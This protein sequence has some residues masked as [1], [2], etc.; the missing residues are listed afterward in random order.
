MKYSEKLQRSTTKIGAKFIDYV[1]E[2]GSWV[3]EVEHFSK[4]RL[5]HDDSD[6]EE[7][8]EAQTKAGA[9]TKVPI[10]VGWTHWALLF[11]LRMYSVWTHWG[12]PV[13][14]TYV[15][16][17]DTLGLSC[18]HYACTVC[19]YTEALLCTL[20]MYSVWTHWGSPVH[21]THVQCEDTLG[22][23]CAH[24][25]QCVDTLRLSCE[26]YTAYTAAYLYHCDYRGGI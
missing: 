2:S 7:E 12:S 13:H 5:V 23:S 9:A 3:F 19:E 26:H 20:R 18:A 8:Q 24:Y 10:C 25:V 15:Q 16:C 6:D 22:L 4:Y 11:T 21:T 17:V 14:T 1:P